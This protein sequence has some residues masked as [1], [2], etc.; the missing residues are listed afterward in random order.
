MAIARDPDFEYNLDNLTRLMEEQE[1]GSTQGARPKKKSKKIM[2]A[3]I[4]DNIPPSTMSSELEL[5]RTRQENL[6]LQLE[7]TKAQLEL[8]KISA[9]NTS[10]SQ[11]QVQNSPEC[12]HASPDLPL[13]NYLAASTPDSRSS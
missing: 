12:L 10:P 2:N 5:E 6:K 11:A 1:I 9:T 4:S 3:K 7:I 13:T 8:A